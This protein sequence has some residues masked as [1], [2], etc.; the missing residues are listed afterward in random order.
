[1]PKWRFKPKQPFQEDSCKCLCPSSASLP[2]LAPS[3]AAAGSQ[4]L[5]GP[6]KT[7]CKRGRSC[8]HSQL[9]TSVSHMDAIAGGT[10]EINKGQRGGTRSHPWGAV[11]TP[12]ASPQHHVPTSS[13]AEGISRAVPAPHRPPCPVPMA[14]PGPQQHRAADFSPSP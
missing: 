12:Q 10:E 3:P 9:S 2:P 11:G 13:G 8:T 6:C 5:T 14:A 1:M 7:P 4:L